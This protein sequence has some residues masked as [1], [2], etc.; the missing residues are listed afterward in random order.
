NYS[1]YVMKLIEESSGIGLDNFISFEL[2][3]HLYDGEH[4]KLEKPC[5]D[6]IVIV[7]EYL[8]QVLLLL[9]DKIFSNTTYPRLIQHLP[10]AI[11]TQIDLAEEECLKRVTELLEM[12]QRPFTLNE[13]Y[14]EIINKIQLA[15]NEHKEKANKNNTP[16]VKTEIRTAL[17][18]PFEFDGLRIELL[19]EKET[20]NYLQIALHSYCKIVQQRVIDNVSM[21]CYYQ[22]ITKC[23]MTLDKKLL[24]MFTSSELFSLMMEPVAQMQKRKVLTASI[25]VFEKA[26]KLGQQHV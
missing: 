8:E 17:T 26:L 18:V 21:I 6:L 5:T 14:L 16:S 11:K 4:H 1:Q 22:F 2:F 24:T 15:H 25:D 12:E 10:D 9:F 20:A 3:V 13:R 7:K 19:A 23:A